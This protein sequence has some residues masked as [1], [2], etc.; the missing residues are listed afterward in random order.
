MC[1]LCH[2]VAK[3]SIISI[4]TFFFIFSNLTIV[5]SSIQNLASCINIDCIAAKTSKTEALCPIDRQSMFV[6]LK[7]DE[8]SF[9]AF[10]FPACFPSGTAV[11]LLLP[12]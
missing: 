11:V 10:I 5:R 7:A 9:G 1:K 12:S 8:E 2:I 3:D 6:N 4:Y